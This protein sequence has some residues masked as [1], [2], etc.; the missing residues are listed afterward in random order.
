MAANVDAG[1]DGGTAP[2]QRYGWWASLRAYLYGRLPLLAESLVSL[3]L[4]AAVIGVDVVALL[5]SHQAETLIDALNSTLRLLTFQSSLDANKSGPGPL[6]Y[7]FNVLFALIFIQSLIGSARAF[8]N[9]RPLDVQ[10]RG[11]AAIC[12]GQVIVCGLGRVGLR[13]VTRLVAQGYRVVVIEKNAAAEHVR[14]AREMQVPVLI[15]DARHAE[16]LRQAGIHRARAVL[17]GIDNDLLNVDIA[18]AAR[19]E[20]PGIRVILRAFDQDFDQALERTFGRHTAFSASAL[21]APTFAGAAV[22]RDLE[23]VLPVAGNLLG[24]AEVQVPEREGALPAAVGEL[25]ATYAVRVLRRV[26]RA[27]RA[28]GIKSASGLHA[29][30]RL[31]LLGRL[32]ALEQ[33]R[34]RAAT[35]PLPIQHPTAEFD[36]VIVC[37]Q[38]KVGYRV[39]RWLWDREPRPRIVVIHTAEGTTLFP[40]EVTSLDGVTTIIGDARKAEVLEQAG[41]GRA[42]AIAAVTSSDLVNLQIGL[43][44]RRLRPNVHVVLR[45][46][47]EALAENLVTFFGIHTAYSTS[48]LAAPTLAAAAAQGGVSHAFFSRGAF[49]ALDDAP[50][51]RGDD[52]TGR[53]VEALRKQYGV[54]VA[55]VERGAAFTLL[56]EGGVTLAEGDRAYLVAELTALAHLRHT[57]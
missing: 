45:V 21:G 2:R 57:T 47:G 18:L 33:V 12:S 35:E 13:V 24:V 43:E 5:N 28:S 37:G 39:V 38:G 46:F 52:L 3:A 30:D 53:T 54:V 19:K 34:L 31:T 8:F 49:F 11:L 7:F 32:S 20:R 17:A 14:R 50:C 48:N 15:G 4:L 40:D 36:T 9:Q 41:L 51:R 42:Y 26:D 56:P 22:S 6:L 1:L 10:Q 44:A 29:G 16:M 27:D 55:G 25:E 23:H